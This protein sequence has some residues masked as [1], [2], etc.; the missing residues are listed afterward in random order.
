MSSLTSSQ[1][2]SPNGHPV[3]TPRNPREVPGQGVSKV[4]G[5]KVDVGMDAFAPR[6]GRS[7]SPSRA[8]P[9]PRLLPELE[10]VAVTRSLQAGAPIQPE[11]TRPPKPGLPRPGRGAGGPSPARTEPP[12]CC[13]ARHRLA[14]STGVPLSLLL[15][16]PPGSSRG[17]PPHRGC[18][19]RA[20]VRACASSE[21]F[22]LDELGG[23]GGGVMSRWG[24]PSQ[25]E[26]CCPRPAGYYGTRCI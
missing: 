6:G 7:E 16:V 3:L 15:T 25:R 17:A 21:P 22:L 24:D 19:F 9:L 5:L 20:P 1:G 4:V 18:G 11:L 14:A 8:G 2:G 26:L 13:S 12:A 23:G 10:F